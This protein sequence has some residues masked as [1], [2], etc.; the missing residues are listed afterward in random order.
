MI[1]PRGGCPLPTLQTQLR[2]ALLENYAEAEGEAIFMHGYLSREH[3]FIQQKNDRELQERHRRELDGGAH[4]PHQNSS[5][6]SPSS[7]QIWQKQ[8][9]RMQADDWRR[10]EELR[11]QEV[12]L[13]MQQRKEQRQ[14]I[15]QSVLTD[16]RM[17]LLGV[18]GVENQD[19]HFWDEKVKRAEAAAIGF[20]RSFEDVGEDEIALVRDLL[21]ALRRVA[22]GA[23]HL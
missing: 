9:R 17:V 4:D 12:P 21:H 18:G 15:G 20:L 19:L 6:C 16:L 11:E 1:I 7:K 3:E 22:A 13:R 8:E 10:L 2:Q 23:F 14:A 5:P